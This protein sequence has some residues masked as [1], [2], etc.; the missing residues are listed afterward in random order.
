MLEFKRREEGFVDAIE[1]GKIVKVSE[2]YARREGLLVLRKSFGAVSEQ[3]TVHKKE[4]EAARSRSSV[5]MDDF[6]RPLSSKASELMKELVENFHWILSRKR[7]DRGLT[8]KKVADDIGESEENIKLIENGVLPADNFVLVNKLEGYYGVVLRRSGVAN[9]FGNLARQTID[10]T[11]NEHPSSLGKSP[12][13]E[14][15]RVARTPKWVL[16]RE[17]RERSEEKQEIEIIEEEPVK[18]D[19]GGENGI[20]DSSP[21]EDDTGSGS[22]L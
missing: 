20:L 7:K 11:K 2:D 14:E 4:E 10:F 16:K 19:E 22:K 5:V 13:I 17:G 9:I 1:D 21:G 18:N 3:G 6:R 8:R 12:E 15:V